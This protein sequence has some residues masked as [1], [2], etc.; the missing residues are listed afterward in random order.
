MDSQRI[1]QNILTSL[2]VFTHERSA[3]FIDLTPTMTE[4]ETIKVKRKEQ[5]KVKYFNKR[6]NNKLRDTDV[7]TFLSYM[8]T[9]TEGVNFS[10]C[11]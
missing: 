11:S 8:H 9:H 4:I 3:S 5:K 6:L 1:F 10:F 2:L 7:Y